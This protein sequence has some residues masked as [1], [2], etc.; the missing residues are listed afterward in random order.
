MAEQAPVFGPKAPPF[1]VDI[2]IPAGSTIELFIQVRRNDDG[3]NGSV[4]TID[5]SYS[6]FSSTQQ[7]FTTVNSH[8]DIVDWFTSNN[9]DAVINSNILN[10][11]EVEVTSFNFAGVTNS[12]ANN[13]GLFSQP[14]SSYVWYVDN[15]GGPNNGEIR[16]V[17]KGEPSEGVPLGGESEEV[18]Y[19]CFLENYK[20]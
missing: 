4:E 8:T 9:I 18:F 20:E 6:S 12:T 19:S 15:S 17:F 16:F 3:L 13:Y 2:D 11:G 10:Q 7:N 5:A 14:N 1:G